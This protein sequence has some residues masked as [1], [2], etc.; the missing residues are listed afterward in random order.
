MSKMFP[1]QRTYKRGTRPYPTKIPWEIAELA[2]SVYVNDHSGGNQSIEK[3]AER[4]GFGPEEMDLFLPD[5]RERCDTIM[6]LKLKIV[7][8]ETELATQGSEQWHK[9][10]IKGRADHHMGPIKDE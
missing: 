2:Y 6:M 4:G 5:W 9:G 3:V 8:L 10:Y 7:S 1:I